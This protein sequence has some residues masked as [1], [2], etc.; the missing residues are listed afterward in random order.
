MDEKR[1]YIYEGMSVPRAVSTM[2][3]PTVIS[4]LIS[5]IYNMADTFFVGQLGDPAQ[6]AAVSI[7]APAA[8]VLTALANLFGIGGASVLSRS[9]GKGEEDGARSAVSFS[10]YAALCTALAI[11][12][13]F[14]LF[15]GALLRLL[16][17]D[18]T[19]EPFAERYARWV[20]VFGAVP[21]LLSM[22]MSHFVRADGAAKLAGYVLSAGGVLNL[23][24]DPVFMFSWGLGLGITG[25]ALATFLSNLMTLCLFAGYFFRQR[26]NSAVSFRPVAFSTGIAPAVLAAG[27]PGMLQTLLASVSNAVLNNV[28]R[29]FGASALASLGIVKKLDQIPM[30]VTIGMAQGIVPLLGYSYSAGNTPRM[31]HTL[32]FTLALAECFSLACVLCYECF[33]GPLVRFFLDDPSTVMTGA[34]MLRVMCLSTPLMAVSFLLITTFQAT[35]KNRVGALLSVLRKGAVDI[36]ILLILGLVSAPLLSLAFVQPVSELAAMLAAIYFLRKNFGA[37]GLEADRK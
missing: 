3:V 25:A 27:L 16:G 19:T 15:P 17:A 30:S 7:A 2:V 9:L 21:S 35:G 14:A 18:G 34:S 32:R 10:M 23:I 26:R 33:A 37:A 28:A 22:V 8:L 13:A 12:A 5:M 20:I 31:K 11:S 1:K 36:P 29:P 6:V 4:Q 24:L